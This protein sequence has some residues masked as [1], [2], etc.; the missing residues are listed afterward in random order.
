MLLRRNDDTVLVEGRP[1]SDLTIEFVASDDAL[2]R[3]VELVPGVA[4]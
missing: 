2:S 4:M 1:R 3:F